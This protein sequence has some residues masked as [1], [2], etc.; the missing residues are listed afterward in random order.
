MNR[1]DF[2]R[3]QRFA[4]LAEQALGISG[5]VID[6]APVETADA[7]LLRFARGAMA[8]TFE[9]VLPFGTA[10][11]QEAAEAALDAIDALESQLTV[12]SQESE[13]GHINRQ[14]A[15]APVQVEERLFE[16]LNL[17]V[18]LGYE[19]EGAVDVS[20]GALVKAWGFYR[21]RGCVPSPE[22]RAEVM[23]R[24]GMKHVTLDLEKRTIAFA[25]AGLEINLGSVG[26]GYA[27]DRVA[28]HLRDG[29]GVRSAVLHGGHSSVLALGVQPGNRRGWPVGLAHPTEPGQRLGI[30]HLR[31]RALGTSAA[32]FQHLEY[33]GKRLGHILDPRTGWPAEGTAA[34]TVT[35]PTA[36][37]ADALATAFYVLGVEKARLYCEQHP[38]IGAVILP[39]ER[40]RPV[41]LGYA[42]D[43]FA[44]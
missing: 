40:R 14:A 2:L 35:A 12:Y 19:T 31:N 21:R 11:A 28:E 17:A 37:E 44:G 42:R 32:T 1:R 30:V 24:I 9:I 36:A 22:E 3:P 10:Q 18:R 16:L 13:I 15:T 38:Y 33:N 7:A 6:P 25:R 4:Q 5:Q 43:E 39:Q 20:V 23:Q 27:L 34:A 29:F 26:K 41:V 8:T